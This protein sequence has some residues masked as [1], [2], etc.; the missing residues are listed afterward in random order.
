MRALYNVGESSDSNPI[1]ASLDGHSNS[2]KETQNLS[3]TSAHAQIEQP[4]VEQRSATD[5]IQQVGRDNE[6]LQPSLPPASAARPKEGSGSVDK[7]ER[8]SPEDVSLPLQQN[9]SAP[10]GEQHSLSHSTVSE[11]VVCDDGEVGS[12]PSLKAGREAHSLSPQPTPRSHTEIHT[13]CPSSEADGVEQSGEND[14]KQLPPVDFSSTH[15]VRRGHHITGEMVSVMIGDAEEYVGGSSYKD[16]LSR[17]RPPT[18]MLFGSRE[19]G[20]SSSELG[21]SDSEFG[22]DKQAKK[23]EQ[24]I[25]Q[26]SDSYL[27][28]LHHQSSHAV[29]SQGEGQE[30]GKV[31]IE[32]GGQMHRLKTSD[33]PLHNSPDCMFHTDIPSVVP[34]PGNVTNN[35]S[36]SGSSGAAS[37]FVYASTAPPTFGFPTPHPS[38]SLFDDVPS[39][40]SKRI[41]PLMH[42]P[43][44]NVQLQGEIEGS[45]LVATRALIPDQD[46]VM[47]SLPGST[48]KDSNT[49]LHLL[50]RN[51]VLG[52]SVEMLRENVSEVDGSNLSR[53]QSCETMNQSDD[54]SPPIAAASS[55]N[56]SR[57]VNELAVTTSQTVTGILLGSQ[58]TIP[59]TVHV[60]ATS[61]R[62]HLLLLGNAVQQTMQSETTVSTKPNNHEISQRVSGDSGCDENV[63]GK[64]LS[65][66]MELDSS[67]VREDLEGKRTST[68]NKSDLGKAEG[69]ADMEV[70]LPNQL[71]Q[72]FDLLQIPEKLPSVATNVDPIGSLGKTKTSQS[73]ACME[74]GGEP[75][76][77]TSETLDNQPQISMSRDRPSPLAATSTGESNKTMRNTDPTELGTMDTPSSAQLATLLL[78]QLESDLNA[79]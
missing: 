25:E 30:R 60:D 8:H 59:E 23:L 18:S 13:V 4:N 76:L 47:A 29:S 48:T 79:A 71:E 69:S 66:N 52:R 17:D 64:P 34:I 19:S 40:G 31:I 56:P 5:S 15:T 61:Q 35:L 50:E 11:P 33:S 28:Q 1:I 54:L 46:R 22:R 12:P 7:L 10:Q 42:H 70:K 37:P 53:S 39:V 51:K 2:K 41:A 68:M 75:N 58:T 14:R 43:L 57:V 3:E 16:T 77:P 27:S 20:D 74:L 32:D 49:L 24:S 44:S 9:N 72:G 36:G 26:I 78:S 45:L 63:E 73:S 55:V 62:S 65:E 38:P 6:A 67:F 21:P